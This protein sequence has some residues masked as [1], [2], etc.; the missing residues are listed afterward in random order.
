MSPEQADPSV[1]DIDTRTD[2]YSLG[3]VLY[4]LLAGLQ[5]FETKQGQ[6]QPLD[7]LLRKLREEEPPRPSTKVSTDRDTL[8]RDRRSARHRAQA[9]GEPAARRSRLDHDEGA[10]E[11]S[12]SPIRRT[13]GTGR[14]HSALSEP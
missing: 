6:K 7:E 1:Q 14:R 11:G 4:V 3:V 10:G 8:G 12:R 9:V 5:P 2:V 13:F